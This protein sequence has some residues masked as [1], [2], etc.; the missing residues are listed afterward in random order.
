MNKK[1]KE[2][3]RVIPQKAYTPQAHPMQ[4]RLDAFR[5]IPSLVTPNPHFTPIGK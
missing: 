5:T 4:H 2:T 3:I 1:I